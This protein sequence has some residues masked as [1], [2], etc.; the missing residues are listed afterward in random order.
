MPY[1]ID[2]PKQILAR[3]KNLTLT[4]D[5]LVKLGI[6]RNLAL[7]YRTELNTPQSSLI[8]SKTA[9]N[10]IKDNLLRRNSVINKKH[11]DLTEDSLIFRIPKSDLLHLIKPHKDDVD[12][13]LV[14][15]FGSQD[16]KEKFT[17]LS[18]FI[19]IMDYKCENPTYENNEISRILPLPLT[20]SK[21]TKAQIQAKL[22]QNNYDSETDSFLERTKTAKF[23]IK[24]FA[25]LNERGGI[26]HYIKKPDTKLGISAYEWLTQYC[27]KS[28]WIYLYP[29]Y[30]VEK[31]YATIILAKS[32]TSLSAIF[33]QLGQLFDEGSSCCSKG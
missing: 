1:F 15:R 3:I 20:F 26:S 13:R 2:E 9:Y 17:N 22:A 10:L 23:K 32:G 14:I 7:Y 24:R 18:L 27:A 28:E 11:V 8:P 29:A 25:G 5:Q 30:D 6:D 16:A 12:K 21:P 31:G 33:G 19:S 4:I